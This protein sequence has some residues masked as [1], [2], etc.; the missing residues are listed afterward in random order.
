VL[1]S[2]KVC[3]SGQHCETVGLKEAISCG[4]EHDPV[5]G[6]QVAVIA[7]T[8]DIKPGTLRDGINP[9]EPDWLSMRHLDTVAICTASHPVIAKHFAKLQGGFFYTVTGSNFDQTTAT[10]VREFGEFLQSLVNGA[11]TPANLE[12]IRKE[13]TEAMA[14]I[15]AAIDSAELRAAVGK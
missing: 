14:A 12:R 10:S 11:M 15:K 5:K 4:A 1:N 2:P 3:T 7:A 9:N 13:G 8:L 6:T